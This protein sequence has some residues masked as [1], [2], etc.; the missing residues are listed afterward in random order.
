MA[1][2]EEISVARRDVEC[3]Q[4]SGVARAWFE[5]E[6][7]VQ[8]AAMVAHQG[9]LDGVKKQIENRDRAAP[10]ILDGGQAAEDGSCPGGEGEGGAYRGGENVRIH[11]VC[12]RSPPC[13]APHLTFCSDVLR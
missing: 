2:R 6:V 13:G 11:R 8:R 5:G 10:R 3:K 9:E 1:G 4:K 7:K 12:G